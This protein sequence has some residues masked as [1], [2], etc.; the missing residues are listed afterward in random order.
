MHH[1]TLLVLL[2][3]LAIA[4]SSQLS[5]DTSEYISGE[6][7]VTFS[8]AG[9]PDQ[10]ETV[11]VPARTGIQELDSVL[12][13]LGLRAIQKFEPS[14]AYSR[15]LGAHP[16]LRMYLIRYDAAIDPEDVRSMLADSPY[17]ERVSVN[18]VLS[19][20]YGG[21]RQVVPASNLFDDQWYFHDPENDDADV[22]A[23]EAWAITAGDSSVVIAIHDTGT[24]VDTTEASCWALDSDLNY[25]WTSEDAGASNCLSSADLN[26]NDSMDPDSE[27]DNVIGF[28]WAPHYA[29]ETDSYKIQ[30]WHSVPHDWRLPGNESPTSMDCDIQIDHGTM[31][32][33]IAAAKK[34]GA[35]NITGLAHDCIVYFVRAGIAPDLTTLSDEIA[36]LRHAALHADVVNMSFGFDEDPGEEF[37]AAV[38]YAADTLDCV[39]VSIT[40]NDGYDDL[41]YWPAAYEDVISVG[42][43]DTD[44]D[45]SSYSNYNKNVLEVDVVAP[46]DNGIMVNRHNSC[47]LSCPCSA[48]E[49]SAVGPLGT[50]F[51]APQVAGVAA[52][53]RTHF[54]T[55][56]Q[57]SVRSR[58]KRSAEYYWDAD[59]LGP[60]KYGAGKV[61][62]YRALT[63]WGT[64]TENTTWSRTDT[65]DETF[66]VS[67]DLVVD[68][69]VTLTINAGTTIKVAPDHE[70]NA[71]WGDDPDKVEIVVKGT[72]IVAGTEANPVVFE[73]FTDS[74]SAAGDWVGIRFE[75][76]S[77]NN[78]LNHVVI[79]HAEKSIE[80]Y[81][82]GHCGECDD[83][84]L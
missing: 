7:I 67:G 30:F 18:R 33:S 56:G 76:G 77:Q 59:P 26:F 27:E 65:R 35:N 5:A 43:I 70:R 80:N 52:L 28:N 23:P 17:V 34:S 64:I 61:N 9:I 19:K 84:Q 1:A 21:T 72:L 45:L 15:T 39:L 2:V 79:K 42:A 57:D 51:A 37:E 53:L 49:Y 13:G 63:E 40:H 74:P 54:P 36:A 66:Y 16:F 10:V 31:V 78:S 50:S 83:R 24:R 11:R 69:L 8:P 29:S 25:L 68:T 22:D 12:S 48:S 71:E 82:P 46:V 62:A 60:N 20:R 44:L 75:E 73:S 32:A 4:A 38:T 55:M 41:V 3:A 47:L 58:I 81:A 6:L 14:Y